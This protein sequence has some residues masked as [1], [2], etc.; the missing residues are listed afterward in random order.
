MKIV[1]TLKKIK[2]AFIWV[3]KS[4]LLR[5][6]FGSCGKNTVIQNPLRIYEPKSVYLA[7]NVK[8]SAGMSI[9]NSPTEKVIIKRYSAIAA[10]C[11]I[12][13]GSHRSTVTIPQ[14]LLGP[15]HIN[16]K[17]SNII[18]NEDVWIGTNVTILSGVEIGRGCIVSAGS[19]VTKS[20]PPYALVVGTPA[21]IIKVKFSIDQIIKHESELYPENERYSREELEQIFAE[22]YQAKKIFGTEEGLSKEALARIESTKKALNY[23]H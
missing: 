16:D 11:T 3:N 19:I 9:L 13:P 2:L 12:V 7:E 17:T 4:F 18:I 15:S 21:K 8:I 6:D 14:F 5:S 20:I 22:Y 10:N 1:D 23:I